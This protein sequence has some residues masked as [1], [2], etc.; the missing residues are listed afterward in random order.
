MD[1]HIVDP[2]MRRWEA[3]LYAGNSVE[4]AEVAGRGFLSMRLRRDTLL[5]HQGFT[6]PPRDVFKIIPGVFQD[7]K[8]RAVE[9]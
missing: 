8:S 4:T 6:R 5:Y 2:N 3:G 7:Y 9:R 1:K